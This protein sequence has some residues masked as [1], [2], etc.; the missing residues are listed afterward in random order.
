MA[1]DGLPDGLGPIR[2]PPP[3][4]GRCSLLAAQCVTVSV[5]FSAVVGGLAPAALTLMTAE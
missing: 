4:A 1:T 5:T 2:S 3:E